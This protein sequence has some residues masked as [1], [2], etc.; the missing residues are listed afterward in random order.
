MPKNDI[1]WIVTSKGVLK[2]SWLKKIADYQEN[3]KVHLVYNLTSRNE[4]HSVSGTAKEVSVPALR[5]GETYQVV[6]IDQ[7][8][9]T[10]SEP[11]TIQ[12]C[13]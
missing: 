7:A 12:A 10:Q 13:K 3:D 4:S 11:I 5:F 6:L 8:N 1:E 9:K 2:L